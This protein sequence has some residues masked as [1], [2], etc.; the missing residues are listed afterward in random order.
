M[1][2]RKYVIKRNAI[3]VGEVIRSDRIY[4]YEGK[5]ESITCHPGQLAASSYYSY[6]S[7]LFVPDE[8]GLSNDLLYRTPAYPILNI[9]DDETCL[10]LGNG[11]VIK[12]AYCLAPLLEYFG[13]K[14]ELY[15][16]DVKRIRKTFFNGSFAKD[17]CKLF[18]Y[19]ETQ[20][21]DYIYFKN[22]I[23]INDPVELQ[24]C[25]A[26]TRL[27]QK[28]GYREFSRIS[29]GVLPE[30][31]FHMLDARGDNS[32]RDVLEDETLNMNA[33]APHKEEGQ[34]RRLRRF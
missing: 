32:L 12:G 20:P 29:N 7:M 1:E 26:N 17:N 24:R 10:N 2:N 14:E 11:I 15:Y 19:K 23:P 6:R 28:M 30:D 33:F 21:E 5:K 9:T 18:G 31:Y 25:I 8:N 27:G 34:I 4:R 3:H 16:E 22:G 13:Y